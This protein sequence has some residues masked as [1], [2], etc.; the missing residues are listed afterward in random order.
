[1]TLESFQDALLLGCRLRHSALTSFN[2][3][4]NAGLDSLCKDQNYNNQQH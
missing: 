4:R 1:L 2:S 3:T